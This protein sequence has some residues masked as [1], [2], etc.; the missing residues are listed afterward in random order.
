[1]TGNDNGAFLQHLCAQLDGVSSL[2]AQVFSVPQSEIIDRLSRF[3][4][5]TQECTTVTEAAKRLS[6]LLEWLHDGVLPGFPQVFAAHPVLSVDPA[7]GDHIAGLSKS[8]VSHHSA[9][10]GNST[11]MVLNTR[12]KDVVGPS[13]NLDAEGWYRRC[14]HQLDV[15]IPEE[16]KRKRDAKVPEAAAVP[17]NQVKNWRA[18]KSQL[19]EEI[20]QRITDQNRRGTIQAELHRVRGPVNEET[21]EGLRERIELLKLVFPTDNELQSEFTDE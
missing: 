14:R 3:V 19:L 18:V 16:G 11:D 1:M 4:G 20:N 15:L 6:K 5:P 17:P 12:L 21:V 10:R 9:W 8:M 2:S 7:F 13:T